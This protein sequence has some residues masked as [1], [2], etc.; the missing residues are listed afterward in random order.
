MGFSKQEYWSGLPFPSPGDLPNLGI[1]PGSPALRADSLLAEPPGKHIKKQRHHFANKGSNCQSYDF[2]CSHVWMWD[3]SIKKAERRR[4]DALNCGAGEDL[5]S[6]LDSKETK[7]VNPKG[8]QPWIFIGS[9][10][11]KA[12]VPILWLP[13]VKSWLIGKD[14]DAG[15]DWE[16]KHRVG[17]WD[18]ITDSMDMRLSK[19]QQ[20]VKDREAWHAEVCGVA[21]SWTPLSN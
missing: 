19:L 21:K 9:T 2:S 17:W 11:A 7:P 13:A 8:N 18:G 12:E 1:E 15:K 20:I 14:P 3:W 16:Q 10:D 4:I 6:R 5:E